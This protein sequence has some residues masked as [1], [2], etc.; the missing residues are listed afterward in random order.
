MSIS[1]DV[2]DQV[3]IDSFNFEVFAFDF[4]FFI[5]VVVNQLNQ[6]LGFG[7]VENG[8]KSLVFGPEVINTVQDQVELFWD[9]EFFPTGNGHFH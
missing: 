4:H 2:L 5:F 9:S 7:F 6:L 8:G 3:L 1:G